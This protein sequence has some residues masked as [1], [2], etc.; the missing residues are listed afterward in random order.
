MDEEVTD[1]S[2]S[3]VATLLLLPEVSS[4]SSICWDGEAS[5]INLGNVSMAHEQIKDIE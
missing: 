4:P 3:F 1:L 2:D 5:E